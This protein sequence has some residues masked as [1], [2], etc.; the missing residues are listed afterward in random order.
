MIIESIRNYFLSCPLLDEF[1]RLDID[2]LGVDALNYT[3]DSVPSETLIKQ[4]VDGGKLNQYIFTFGSRE[5]Y[6]ADVLQ[7]IDNSGFY[8]KL[9]V[10]IE[11]QNENEIY[12]ILGDNQDPLKVEVVT[13][14]YLMGATENLARYQIQLRLT[15]YED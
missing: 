12:P 15:Y 9:T 6:G 5:Y 7:N 13:S 11:E 14:G 2:Y 3:I 4:Y 1:A 10:W 8:E